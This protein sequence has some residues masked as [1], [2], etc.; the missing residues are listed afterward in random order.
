S[1]LDRALRASGFECRVLLREIIS[2]G[3]V[4]ASA[5]QEHPFSNR[6]PSAGRGAAGRGADQSWG[7]CL[8]RKTGERAAAFASKTARRQSA[9]SRR[10]S[11]EDQIER[12]GRFKKLKIRR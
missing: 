12:H 6:S 1:G 8:V 4:H 2:G 5:I 10:H 11:D 9:S 3:H 7:W